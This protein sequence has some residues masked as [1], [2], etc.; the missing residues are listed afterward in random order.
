MAEISVIIP[1]YNAGQYIEKC[2]DALC[3][4]TFS[5]IEILCI[6]DGSSDDTWQHI[7][8]HAAEDKRIRAWRQQNAGPAATRNRG[9]QNASAPYIMFCDADDW[10]EPD[11]CRRMLE[12]MKT[13]D[14]DT[15]VSLLPCGGGRL[16][17]RRAGNFRKSLQFVVKRSFCN[18][19]QALSTNLGRVVEQ[20]IQERADRSL[21]HLFSGGVRA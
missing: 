18:D 20:D 2:L 11:F 16:R 14:T 13:E 10:Y 4:Q 21:R 1:V 8:K 3:R 19:G 5:D 7:A 9:L 15:A 6:D 17:L 12:I